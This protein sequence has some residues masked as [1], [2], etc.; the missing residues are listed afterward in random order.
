MFASGRFATYQ[1]RLSRGMATRDGRIAG[2]QVAL[3]R[4]QILALAEV[5]ARD[6]EAVHHLDDA[7]LLRCVGPVA[8]VRLRPTA[9]NAES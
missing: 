6:A 7:T 3:T 2:K 5:G 8:L 1:S 4:G 9:P